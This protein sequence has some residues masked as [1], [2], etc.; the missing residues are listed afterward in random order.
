MINDDKSTVR[1]VGIFSMTQRT[2]PTRCCPRGEVV[3]SNYTDP[4]MIAY[5]VKVIADHVDVC[6]VTKDG[7]RQVVI[8]DVCYTAYSDAALDG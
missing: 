7:S 2:V 4:A 1:K 6:R 3:G 8:D 5:V